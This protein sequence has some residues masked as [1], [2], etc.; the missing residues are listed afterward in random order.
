MRD[1][2]LRP[3]MMLGEDGKF[4]GMFL[5]VDC[6]WQVEGEDLFFVLSELYNVLDKN[7]MVDGQESD[8]R[9]IFFIQ[10]KR[11]KISMPMLTPL[12]HPAT[13]HSRSCS[14]MNIHSGCMMPAYV[15]SISRPDW[16]QHSLGVPRQ[17]QDRSQV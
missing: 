3:G 12:S 14:N 6:I 1:E 7:I 10:L 15:L 2:T 16:S 13:I 17:C 8:S 11:M 9:C 4:E 5:D